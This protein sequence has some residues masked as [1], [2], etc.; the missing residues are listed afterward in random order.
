[1]PPPLL[2]MGLMARKTDPLLAVNGPI[3]LSP[4]QRSFCQTI[5]ANLRVD[6]ARRMSDRL[7]FHLGRFLLD[8][9]EAVNME[10]ATLLARALSEAL[11]TF[12]EYSPDKREWLRVG[13]E[14]FVRDDDADPDLDAVGGLNDDAIVISGVLEHCGR[15]DLAKQ[16]RDYQA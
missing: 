15:H 14:Y 6:D 4:S 13:V 9:N 16:I 11:R 3:I 8:A 2:R 1:M 7:A 10:L 12:P 5:R